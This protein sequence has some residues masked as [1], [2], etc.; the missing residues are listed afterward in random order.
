M[1]T[2]V[3]YTLGKRIPLKKKNQT[4]TSKAGSA[5][6]KTQSILFFHARGELF[7]RLW[8]PG[9]VREGAGS[10]TSLLRSGCRKVG[11]TIFQDSRKI[12]KTDTKF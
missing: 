6:E 2:G 7:S 5:D 9:D 4:N 1:T 12:K 11:F 10:E 8:V 3:S